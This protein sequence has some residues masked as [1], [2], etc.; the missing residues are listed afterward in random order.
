MRFI[1]LF[2]VA[3]AAISICQ[4]ATAGTGTCSASLSK[5]CA[6]CQD[7][8]TRCAYCRSG[9]QCM[10]SKANN[11]Y[12]SANAAWNCPAAA[13]PNCLSCSPACPGTGGAMKC[14]SWTAQMGCVLCAAGYKPKQ[15][16]TPLA[17]KTCGWAN[18]TTCVPL[19]GR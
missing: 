5:V 17:A 7:I 12:C 3:M 19:N 15:S 1:L 18:V 2:V 6:G 16:S 9:Y 8:N 11:C 14:Q 10:G 13:G 4:G